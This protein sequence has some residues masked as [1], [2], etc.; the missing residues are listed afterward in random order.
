MKKVSQT[1][2]TQA[3][4][5]EAYCVLEEEARQHPEL[6]VFLPE[7]LDLNEQACTLIERYMAKAAVKAAT[8]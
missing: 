4:I 6:R 5:I 8:E 7:L 3:S 2:R 1:L